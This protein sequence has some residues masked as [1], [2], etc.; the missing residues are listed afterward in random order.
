MLV[1]VKLPLPDDDDSLK[2]LALVVRQS[3]S[4]LSKRLILQCASSFLKTEMMF[5]SMRAPV[6]RGKSD[7]IRALAVVT[8]VTQSFARAYLLLRLRRSSHP[9]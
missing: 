6:I 7:P 4:C 5:L 3:S 1:V 8:S 9:F 2:V